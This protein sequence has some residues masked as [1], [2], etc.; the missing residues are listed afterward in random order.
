MISCNTMLIKIDNCILSCRDNI[1]SAKQKYFGFGDDLYLMSH[2]WGFEIT[3][4]PKVYHGLLHI[5]NGDEDVLVPLGLQEC[6]K[7]LVSNYFFTSF[8]QHRNHSIMTSNMAFVDFV[9][10]AY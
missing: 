8:F 5:W 4:V 1:E 10:F 6:I 7:K 9:S 3:D 2:N